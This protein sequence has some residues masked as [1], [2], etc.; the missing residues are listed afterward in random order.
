[1]NLPLPDPITDYS[2]R[3]DYV[4]YRARA[5]YVLQNRPGFNLRYWGRI[6]RV[7]P[8]I[9]RLQSHMGWS[10]EYALV[11]KALLIGRMTCVFIDHLVERL[12]EAGLT[13]QHELRAEWERQYGHFIDLFLRLNSIPDGEDILFMMHRL[14]HYTVP[15]PRLLATRL[16]H[17]HYFE[18]LLAKGSGLV[19]EERAIHMLHANRPA[20]IIARKLCAWASL[21]ADFCERR[22][23]E[24]W[25]AAYAHCMLRFYTHI[26]HH[27][28]VF[29]AILMNA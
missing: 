16:R 13:S 23:G 21:Y 20:R 28:A 27:P 26:R 12:A 22:T 24:T 25:G 11:F 2:R 17:W 19:P 9:D 8:R 1:M 5:D 3:T 4:R 14:H 15:S 7:S 18:R 6:G 10:H 29:V